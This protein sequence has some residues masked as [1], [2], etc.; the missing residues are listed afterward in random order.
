MMADGTIRPYK[1]HQQALGLDDSGKVRLVSIADTRHLLIFSAI[2][3][4]TGLSSN[5]MER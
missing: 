1:N 4:E 3:E 5:F 2:L